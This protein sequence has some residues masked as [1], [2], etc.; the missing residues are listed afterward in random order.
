MFSL[1]E[2]SRRRGC[3]CASVLLENSKCVLRQ[4]QHERNTS[5]FS[6]TDPFVLILSTCSDR[7]FDKLRTG[8]SKHAVN[9]SNR[10]NRGVFRSLLDI[11]KKG[12]I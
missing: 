5:V 12:D 2:S 9:L 11:R 10:M 6:I 1:R 4:A 8:L 3:L 7:P